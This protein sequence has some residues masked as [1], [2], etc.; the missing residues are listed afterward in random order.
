MN[1]AIDSGNTFTKIGIFENGQITHHL[2]IKNEE[3]SPSSIPANFSK[4]IISSVSNVD[5]S[6][7]STNRNVLFLSGSTK[8]PVH[9]KYKTPLSLGMDRLAAVVGATTQYPNQNCLIVN[10]GT[11]ITFDIIDENSDYLGGS[12]SPGINL[13][14][15]ALNSFTA[16]LPLIERK[17]LNPALAGLSTDQSIESGVLNGVAA[18]VEGLIKEYYTLYPSLKVILTG[19]DADFFETRLK[20]LI[21]VV[22]ELVLTGLN[23]ILEYNVIE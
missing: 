16:R 13:R 4:A 6:F 8:V 17:T 11:C 12:I 7:L 18:E 19:G 10:A 23:R 1:I 20:G 22:P 15:K 9:V 21:F 3:M 2:K 14:F 5:F